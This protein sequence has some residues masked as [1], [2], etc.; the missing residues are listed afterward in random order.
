MNVKVYKPCLIVKSIAIFYSKNK[1]N[2]NEGLNC[3][4]KSLK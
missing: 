2:F 1:V 4:K 3:L